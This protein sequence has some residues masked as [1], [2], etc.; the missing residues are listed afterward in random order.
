MRF[1]VHTVALRCLIALLCVIATAPR[2]AAQQPAAIPVGVLPA[3][4]RPITQATEFVGRVEAVERVE[5]RDGVPF[6]RKIA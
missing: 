1:Q 2:I 6:F 3:E 4:L 5:I